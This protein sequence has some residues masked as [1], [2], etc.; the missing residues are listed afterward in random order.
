[1]SS[2]KNT[3]PGDMLA[4]IFR[5][6]TELNDYVFIKNRLKDNHGHDLTMQS[7]YNAAENGELKVNELPNIWL[8][9]YAKAMEEELKE[10]NQDLLWKW[11]SKDEVDVQNARVELIDILHFLVSAMICAGLTPAKVFDVYRQKHAVNLN[12][13]DQGYSKATKSE[14]DNRD[15]G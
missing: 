1:M 13:Q 10:L 11:W 3:T 4:E 14:D 9:R 6:Q 5:M 7:I 2:A 15:I 8:S 12:R